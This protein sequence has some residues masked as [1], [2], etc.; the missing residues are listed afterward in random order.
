[1]SR[2]RGRPR[3]VSDDQVEGVITFILSTT[4]N[5]RHALVHAIDGRRAGDE[6]DGGVVDLV[7]VRIGATQTGFVETVSK[8]PLFVDKVREVVGL[9]LNPPERALGAVCGHKDPDPSAQPHRTGVSDA[10]GH[11]GARQPRRRAP[12]H[13]Q[14]VCRTGPDHR[15]EGLSALRPCMA[16]TAPQEVLAF[17]END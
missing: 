2:G 17:P 14:P 15:Q 12:R 7:G 1:M 9:Y 3:T 11:A 6:P 10:A 8:D 4:P 5:Q 13:L 16:A